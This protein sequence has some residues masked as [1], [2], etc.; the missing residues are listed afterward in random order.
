[1]EK[2]T[3]D[4]VFDII[5]SMKKPPKIIRDRSGYFHLLYDSGKRQVS[6]FHTIKD[7]LDSLNEEI[8]KRKIMEK[9][10]EK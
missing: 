7:V 9:V 1:M 6:F 4:M 3:L 10:G 2:S 8:E 5:D